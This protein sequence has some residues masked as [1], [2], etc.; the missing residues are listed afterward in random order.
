MVPWQQ[1]PMYGGVSTHSLDDLVA[2]V[3]GREYRDRRHHRDQHVAYIVLRGEITDLRDR[4]QPR[5]LEPAHCGII[6]EAKDLA[7]LPV[8]GM[9]EA[10][11]H[12]LNSFFTYAVTA[13]ILWNPCCKCNLH[14]YPN[15]DVDYTS[16]KGE[17][18]KPW[19][20]FW[21]RFILPCQPEP[22]CEGF[23]NCPV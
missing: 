3:C 8:R 17:L 7:D 4:L 9:D 1:V 14:V 2:R 13:S 6:D 21:R 22:Q 15:W 23:G 10:E 20:R 19:P 12:S 11:C 5:Q 16:A 18:S